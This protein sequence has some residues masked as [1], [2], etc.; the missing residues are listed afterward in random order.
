MAGGAHETDA[1]VPEDRSNLV[2]EPL[3]S[4]GTVGRLVRHAWVGQ[5]SYHREFLVKIPIIRNVMLYS[6]DHVRQYLRVASQAPP[7]PAYRMNK[8]P[9][10]NFP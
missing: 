6:Y 7:L 5:I 10:R 9:D 8:I 2:A 4:N 3:K 1:Y